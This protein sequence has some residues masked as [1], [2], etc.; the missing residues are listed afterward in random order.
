[1]SL[2]TNSSWLP[3]GTVAMPL[4]SRLKPVPYLSIAYN[5]N[6]SVYMLQAAIYSASNFITIFVTKYCTLLHMLQTS[7]FAK[8][9]GA[10]I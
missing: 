6:A 3:W 8:G 1:M 2:T 5:S 4:I 7:A 9:K 10:Y